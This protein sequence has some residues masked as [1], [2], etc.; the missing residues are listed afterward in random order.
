MPGTLR[1]RFQFH[2]RAEGV[3]PWVAELTAVP[4]EKMVAYWTDRF[5]AHSGSER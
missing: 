3:L 2:T 5:R 1:E 4:L